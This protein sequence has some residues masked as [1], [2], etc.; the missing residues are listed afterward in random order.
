MSA[1]GWISVLWALKCITGMFHCLW[2][3]WSLLIPD[4]SPSADRYHV[5]WQKAPEQLLNA[6]CERRETFRDQAYMFHYKFLQ[7]GCRLYL[8]F[9]WYHGLSLQWCP[10]TWDLKVVF[11]KTDAQSV[12]NSKTW[13]LPQRVRVLL[14]LFSIALTSFPSFHLNPPHSLRP[15]LLS[16][17]CWL[18]SQLTVFYWSTD[19]P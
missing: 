3:L 14:P 10:H 16:L 7:T 4:K 6:L 19:R 9:T 1:Q 13:K 18:I 2:A 5:M 8:T 15:P 11:T 17:T 12:R